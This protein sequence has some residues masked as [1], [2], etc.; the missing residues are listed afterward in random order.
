M[1]QPS[2]YHWAEQL[3]VL[4]THGANLLDAL[5]RVCKVFDAAATTY[6]ATLVAAGQPALPGAAAASSSS[7]RRIPQPADRL[8]ITCDPDLL[9]ITKILIK[10][11]PEVPDLSMSPGFAY[12]QKAQSEI[13]DDLK[14]TFEVMTAVAEFH[15]TAIAVLQQSVHMMH[16]D[17]LYT[18]NLATLFLDVTR[19][20]VALTLTFSTMAAHPDLL[21]L[22]PAAFAK[23]HHLIH[24]T[25][26]P[27]FPRL[28]AFAAEV[29]ECAGAGTATAATAAAIR[30]LQERWTMLAPKTAAL[31]AELGRVVEGKARAAGRGMRASGVFSL[32]AVLNGGIVAA[33]DLK[34]L[35]EY[36]EH[37]CLFETVCCAAL[38]CPNELLANA[39]LA[40]TV[41]FCFDYSFIAPT[42]HKMLDIPSSFEALGRVCAGL[43]KWTRSLSESLAGKL[44]AIEA[45][46][47]ERREYVLQQLGKIYHLSNDDH[48][49]A[50]K[51]PV[52][53]SALAFAR[54]EL[55]W[56]FAH[57]RT[58]VRDKKRYKKRATA[59][60]PR[61]AELIWLVKAVSGR[62]RLNAD[63]I[64]SFSAIELRDV[65]APKLA[66]EIEECLDDRAEKAVEYVMLE[67]VF[68]RVREVE[69]LDR[70]DLLGSVDLEGLRL[71]FRRFEALAV[72]PASTFPAPRLELLNAAF[73]AFDCWSRWFDR[74][75]D[76]VEQAARLGCLWEHMDALLVHVEEAC[77]R[78]K[79][80]GAGA[81][82]GGGEDRFVG[83]FLWIAEDFLRVDV[84]FWPQETLNISAATKVYLEQATAVIVA[85]TAQTVHDVAMTSATLARE[86][87]QS[88]P[89]DALPSSTDELSSSAKASSW[90]GGSMARDKSE[91]AVKGSERWLRGR[92]KRTVALEDQRQRAGELIEALA[93][94]PTL[95]VKGTEWRPLGALIH[96][97]CRKVP[98]ARYNEASYAATLRSSK[99]AKAKDQNQSS[100]QQGTVLAFYAL[101]YCEF[102]SSKSSLVSSHYWS[103]RECFVSRPGSTPQ[104]EHF[105]DVQE[106]SA[107]CE[108]I[109]PAG[110]Q[111]IDER[112]ARIVAN[113]VRSIKETINQNLE[114]LVQLKEAWTLEAK[115]IELLKKMKNV[116]DFSLHCSI[117]G[118]VCRFRQLLAS[119]LKR[120]LSQKAPSLVRCVAAARSHGTFE[121][122]NFQHDRRVIDLVL[123]E[124][125]FADLFDSD[126]YLIDQLNFIAA[127]PR[128]W[129]LLPTLQAVTFWHIATDSDTVYNPR[130]D[131]LENNAHMATFA[132]PTLL[133]TVFKILPTPKETSSK[134]EAI[135]NAVNAVI[136]MSALFLNRLRAS[137]LAGPQSRSVDSAFLLLH[138]FCAA[139]PAKSADFDDQLQ[140]QLPWVAARLALADLWQHATAPRATGGIP[141]ILSWRPSAT[142]S[143]EYAAAPQHAALS[144]GEDCII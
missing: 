29:A 1:G 34:N 137:P 27:S 90:W 22:L 143:V 44:P 5:A 100:T 51:L 93:S 42:I 133:A 87:H 67:R 47:C 73:L 71:D 78:K 104:A 66:G 127:D 80:A 11:F 89:G 105:S 8:I 38:L 107:L 92:D 28:A 9:P 85:E 48:I 76:E 101:W 33:V 106:L 139:C 60:D 83:G 16:L 118:F 84:R 58:D 46:H 113:S 81:G 36:T 75:D 56:Y 50:S 94:V 96:G 116:Q 61:V 20:L 124:V 117:I 79:G 59:A 136:Q 122:E 6:S 26:H 119:A 132:F 102:A 54:D 123:K 65:V 69:T 103:S 32:A 17:F 109:G 49:L 99:S 134:Q 121:A 138:K 40:E 21:L 24:G 15:D 88:V 4:K 55:V 125:G 62:L 128:G 126:A 35:K 77:A 142:K 135:S 53:M 52:I 30:R 43:S 72:L 7:A 31:V 39:E 115:A 2:A 110:A 70:M 95:E 114:P 112:L 57:W 64:R 45:T 97:N 130:F 98:Q 68:A 144:A 141:A 19:L 63:A 82:G 111:L 140:V 14:S 91:S 74:L 25:A 3:T 86:L 23:S 120:V 41:A 108:I 10:K 129:G 12:F 37:P 18:P 13:Y 131:G